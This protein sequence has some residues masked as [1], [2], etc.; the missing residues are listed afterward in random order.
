MCQVPVQPLG[1]TAVSPGPISVESLP[2]VVTVI[3]PYRTY[4]N[5]LLSSVQC[6]RPGVH[7]QTPASWS[8]SFQIVVPDVCIGSP[9]A[10]G[11]APQ[12]SSS[13]LLAVSRKGG[14]RLAVV[15]MAGESSPSW[16]VPVQVVLH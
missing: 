9:V 10:S 1:N 2:S 5:S 3:R 12:S 13:A 11:R 6:D 15:V 4:T 7:S 16:P 8:P 14:S